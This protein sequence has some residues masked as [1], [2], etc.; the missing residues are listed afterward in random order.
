MSTLAKL[1]V[2][3]AASTAAVVSFGIR[4][5]AP[6]PLSSVQATNLFARFLSTP[7]QHVD[8]YQTT[9]SKP[10][11]VELAAKA[12][13]QSPVF[14][15]ERVIL[16]LAG[17]GSTTD[18]EIDAMAFKEGEHV[19]T[20]RVLETKENEVLFCWDESDAVNGHSWLAVTDSG[21]TLL[22]G[23]TIRNRSAFI[24]WVTPLHLVY[25]QIVLA[26]ARYQLERSAV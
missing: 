6:T 16:R 23:S 8:V 5:I 7:D 13:F 12:F 3:A 22:F 18:A 14:Q 20:F 2:V 11:S 21:H 15:A 25:A 19:A 10:V 4:N 26:S 9:L 1:S 24:R 17:A